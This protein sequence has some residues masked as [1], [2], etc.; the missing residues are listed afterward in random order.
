MAMVELQKYHFVE[1][2][3]ALESLIEAIAP[4]K[5]SLV[6]QVIVTCLETV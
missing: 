4:D 6:V 2:T 1:Y 3:S 5:V